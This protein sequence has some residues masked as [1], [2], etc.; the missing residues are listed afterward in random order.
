MMKKS[1]KLFPNS[2]LESRPE[3]G[4]VGQLMDVDLNRTFW[5]EFNIRGNSKLVK[6]K[7][8]SENNKINI[9][10]KIKS[11]LFEGGTVLKE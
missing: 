3:K 1:I 6:L 9:I 4:T 7:K 10:C 11:V 2:Y 8:Y 5:T